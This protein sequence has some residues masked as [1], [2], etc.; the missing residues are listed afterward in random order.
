M[1]HDTPLSP[2]KQFRS[3]RHMSLEAFGAMFDPAFNKSTI[4][5]WER[6]GVPLERC[7]EVEEATGISRYLL[8]PDVFDLS[9]IPEA[10][11]Q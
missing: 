4:L 10:L 5:K 8:R 3:D 6:E 9:K 7:L 1:Q 11:A 2:I